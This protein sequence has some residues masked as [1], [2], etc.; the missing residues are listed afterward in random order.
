MALMEVDPHGAAAARGSGPVVL[1]RPE[2]RPVHAALGHGAGPRHAQ[3]C[4]RADHWLLHRAHRWRHFRRP[5]LAIRPPPA[6]HLR[7]T[8]FDLDRGHALL[9]RRA[10]L[11]EG[12]GT[13]VR[14]TDVLGDGRH[15][16][17][18]PD[19]AP[20][21][22]VRPRVRGAASANAGC[23][24]VHDGRRKLHWVLHHAD[25]RDPGGAHVRAHA[26]H[27]PAQHF[28]HR[29]AVRRRD[30][31]APVEGPGC[32]EAVVLLAGVWG[33]R[34]GA[35]EPVPALPLG[36]RPVPGLDRQHSL[37]HLRWPVV[38]QLRLRRRPERPR[39]LPG[40]AGLRGRH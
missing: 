24:R 12:Q 19:A 8:G 18:A 38:R 7:R 22:C 6:G 9:L 5:D 31:D 39:G 37:G 15:H 29:R 20:R 4:R 33:G 2:Q 26:R 23:L 16:Q 13:D 30:G 34:G 28:L 36:G 35:V 14:C 17:R 1:P 40:E 21:A 3:Q 27:L 25:L 11:S 10:P 32:A